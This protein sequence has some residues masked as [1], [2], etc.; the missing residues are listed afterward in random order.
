MTY[1]LTGSALCLQFTKAV[2]SKQVAQQDAE[3]ARFVVMRADQ[4]PCCVLQCCPVLVHY[5]A[6]DGVCHTQ[7]LRNTC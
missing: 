4:V 7:L 5:I 1:L 3:R 2:E 6:Y